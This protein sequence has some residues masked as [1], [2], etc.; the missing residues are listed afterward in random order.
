LMLFRSVRRPA[1]AVRLEH[2]LLRAPEPK[3]KR[4]ND[5]MGVHELWM[6]ADNAL[7]APAALEVRDRRSAE[8]GRQPLREPPTTRK[9]GKNKI[10]SRGV[11]QMKRPAAQPNP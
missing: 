11:S 10:R 5:F 3:I 1:S 6:T 8:P 9:I 7:E 4:A 2:E